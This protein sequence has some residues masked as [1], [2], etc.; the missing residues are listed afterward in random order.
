MSGSWGIVGGG[1][2]GMTLAYR[3]A[4]RGERV[5]LLEA[6]DRLGGLASP[7]SLGDI[8]WDR[9]YHVILQSDTRLQSL[10]GELGLA[11]ELCWVE[12]RTGFYA[13]GS[14]YSMSSLLDFFRFPPLRLVDKLRLGLTL[15]V[16]SRIRDG[17]RL[18]E[19]PVADWL[20]RWSGP[21]ALNE[22]W[23]PLL[24][25]K[26]GENYRFASAS[27]IWAIIARLNRARSAGRKREVLGYVRGGYARILEAFANRLGEVGVETLSGCPVSAVKG[28]GRSITVEC[29]GGK[30]MRFERVVVT[31]AAPIAERL[32][33]GLAPR[34]RELLKGIRY[35][36]IVC[37]SLLLERPLT[38]YYVTNI[39]DPAVPFTAVVD[40]SAL[41]DPAQLSGHGLVYLP[42]YVAPGDSF[43]ARSDEEIRTEFLAALSR[44]FP[45]FRSEELLA[46]R[47]SRV[48][49]VLAISTL[50]YSK[51][52]PPIDTS[53]PGL[54]IVSSAHIVNGTLNVNETLELAETVLPRLQ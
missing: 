11:D 50:R 22:I 32:C 38:Q 18:E 10:L 41:V 52:L 24:R 27:F 31:A 37:A 9:H 6:G 46:F 8:V 1:M 17:E 35:Q 43:F 47:V 39:T 25:A 33:P 19:I 44:M 29:P 51:R 16:A 49:H 53:V 2:L 5:T 36:G 13:A 45:S 54:Q 21:H 15:F 23:L 34:E 7:W 4:Q 26:L 42:K 12:T 3:L 28:N 14:M 30:S 40:M 20:R 48:R